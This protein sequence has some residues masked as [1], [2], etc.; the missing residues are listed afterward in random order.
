MI[1]DSIHIKNFRSILDEILYCKPLTVLVGANGSGK[2]SFLQAVNLFYN[3]SLK[4]EEEDFYNRDTS[5]DISITITYKV[6]SEQV[7]KQFVYYIQ[8]NELKIEQVIVWDEGRINIKYYGF[9]FINTDFNEV[10]EAF[11]RKDRGV[12]GKNAYKALLDNDKYKDFPNLTTQDTIKHY[13]DEWEVKNEKKCTLIQKDDGNFFGFKKGAPGYLKNFIDLLFIPAV[14]EAADEA[15]DNKGS[16]LTYLMDFVVRNNLEQNDEIKK[17]KED[18]REKYEEIMKPIDEKEINDLSND[19]SNT[20]KTYI[21]DASI[22]LNRVSVDNF[23][24]PVP[25]AN[26]KLL[27]NGYLASVTRTGH[28]LQRALI[29]TLFQYLTMNQPV[30][31][32]SENS[33]DNNNVLNLIFAIEEPE[34]YQHPN[35]QRSIA[36]ILLKLSTGEIDSIIKPQII[37]TTHSPLFVGIDRIDQIRLVRKNNKEANNKSSKIIS[38]TLNNVS[39]CIKELDGKLDGKYDGET[40]LPRLKAVMT[41][42]MNEG[43]FADIVVLVEGEDDRAAILGLSKSMGYEFEQMGI[44]V[45]P[46]I[47]KNNIDRPYII[48]TQ[49]GIPVYVVWDSDSNKGETKGI[50]EVCGRRLDSKSDPKDNKRLLRLVGFS[51]EEDWPEY[52]EDKFACFKNNLED[53]LKNEIGIDI[54]NECLAKCQ[55]EYGISKLKHAIKNP[56]VIMNIISQAKNKGQISK[57]LEKII[58]KVILLLKKN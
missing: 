57:T 10:R 19:L 15:C 40:L 22:K 29:L 18:F 4:I 21:P 34:L 37:Y 43:F 17:F 14:H 24:F 16:I 9:R 49:L 8:N 55:E 20:L 41:P 27:E 25:K 50:C 31:K 42:L 3:P 44:S 54:F 5:T 30:K 39:K 45:I 6:L 36:E 47:G 1:I 53:T 51:K 7:K 58:N 33:E 38:T 28:G 56:N 12:A 52:V 23:D 26:V 35:R 11:E 2:S 32:K 13:L 48:F 46:C